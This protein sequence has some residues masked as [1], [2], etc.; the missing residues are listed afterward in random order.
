MN[1]PGKDLNSSLIIIDLKEVK[2][3]RIVLILILLIFL[4]GCA[5]KQEEVLPQPPSGEVSVYKGFWMPTA[6]YY[7]HDGQSMTDEKLAKDVGANI[8]GLGPTVKINAKG[9][10]KYAEPFSSDNVEKQLAILAK[11]Y[12]EAGIRIHLVVE[13]FYEEEFTQKGGEPQ[14]IPRAVATKQGFLDK[15]DLIVEDMAVLAEKYQVEMFSPMNEPD[16]KLG[17]ETSSEWGQRILPIV[18]RNYNGKVVF[19]GSL[20]HDLD[21]AISFKGYDA[22]GFSSS[23]GGGGI[24]GYEQEAVSAIQKILGWAQRDGVPEVIATEFGTWSEASRFDEN[25]KITAHRIIFQQGKG[26]LKGFMV[27]DPPPDQGWSLKQSPELLEEIKAWFKEL[28]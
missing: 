26:K 16:Y 14:P 9:E 24:E 3:K 1:I 19:K 20:S 6:F 25:T 18:R 27:F 13:V 5:G 28:S 4:S 23:P 22:I 12:Y 2:M 11:K 17:A 8:V 7:P 10:V 15:Y 21:D